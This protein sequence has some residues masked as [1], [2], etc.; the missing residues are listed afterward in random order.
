MR[1]MECYTQITI[2]NSYKN[3]KELQE[4][5]LFQ[6]QFIESGIKHIPFHV[7]DKLQVF[8]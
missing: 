3:G 2:S 5:K 6:I 7:N 1:K 4:Q 8:M